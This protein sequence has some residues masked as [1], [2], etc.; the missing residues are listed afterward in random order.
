MSFRGTFFYFWEFSQNLFFFNMTPSDAVVGRL[1]T[2]GEANGSC[3]AA[4]TQRQD[5][6]VPPGPPASYAYGPLLGGP[7]P[8]TGDGRLMANGD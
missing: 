6:Y 5:K 2:L 4:N 3:V 8:K 7:K 1:A